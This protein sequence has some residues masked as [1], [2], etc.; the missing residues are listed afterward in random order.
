VIPKPIDSALARFAQQRLELGE[1]LLDRI[2][3]GRV[4]R[5]IQDAGAPGSNG[6]RNARDLVAGQIVGN[7]DV[8]RAER[9][10]QELTHPGQEHLAVHGAID[11][12]RGCH[13]AVAQASNEGGGLPMSMRHRR[14][15]ALAAPSTAIAARHVRAGCRLIQEHQPLRR[16]AGLRGAPLLA[17]LLHVG[18][19]LLAGVQRFF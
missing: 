6:L 3:I 9:G 5:Q 14:H 16:Q 2:E 10:A 18:P 7:D 13:A 15:A 1:H 4:R 17:R 8:S 11:D 12:Q 19:I